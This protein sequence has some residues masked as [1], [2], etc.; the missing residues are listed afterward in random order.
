MTCQAARKAALKRTDSGVPQCNVTNEYQRWQISPRIRARSGDSTIG[1]S[2]DGERVVD[3][4]RWQ[5][6]QG[7]SNVISCSNDKI[8]PWVMESG[9][10]RVASRLCL[11]TW[12][13]PV[14]AFERILGVSIAMQMGG[15]VSVDEGLRYYVRPAGPMR[16]ICRTP[17]RV[18]QIGM[19]YL[20][21]GICRRAWCKKYTYTQSQR[22]SMKEQGVC[23][24]FSP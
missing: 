13:L 16:R 19:G 2:K 11:Y 20:N 1:D 24:P 22:Q 5:V 14:L 23:A 12:T 4:C 9:V 18:V 6:G 10:P 3:W 8:G 21:Q 7:V 17:D 15:M